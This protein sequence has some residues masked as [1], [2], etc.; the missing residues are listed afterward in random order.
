MIAGH[1]QRW[2]PPGSIPGEYGLRRL[3]VDQ[4]RK[5][6]SVLHRGQEKS[7]ATD[8]VVLIPGPR[9]EIEIVKEVFHLYADQRRG[10]E[11]IAEMLN[12]RGLLAKGE[13]RG[14]GT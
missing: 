4:D 7:I 6:K 13:G 8:R 3:L 12:R 9:E 5:S 11:E 14:R 10:P 2:K 1:S